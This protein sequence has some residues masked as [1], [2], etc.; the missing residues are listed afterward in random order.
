MLKFRYLAFAAFLSALAPSTFAN[1]LTISET[2]SF[3]FTGTCVT[4]CTGFGTA[5]LVL[6]DYTQGQDITANNFVSFTYNSNILSLFFN[7]SDL[8]SI[9]GNL[10]AVLPA[11]ADMNIVGYDET[12]ATS[13]P[14]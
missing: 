4:D 8:N 7:A 10:P 14:V 3:S 13:L 2:E 6:T 1:A 12:L 11:P 9:S 5:T